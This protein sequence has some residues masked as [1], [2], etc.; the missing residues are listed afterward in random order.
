MT[1]LRRRGLLAGLIAAPLPAAPVLAAPLLAAPLL[2]VPSPAAAAPTAA[3]HS[4]PVSLV[5]GTAEPGGDYVVYGPAW[6]ALATRASG[7]HIS[8]RAT[9]GPSQNIILIEQGAAQLGMTSL[10]V[11]RQAWEGI[12]GWTHAMRLRRARALFPMYPS[13]FHG[14]ARLGTGILRIADLSGRTVGIGPRGGT[15]AEYVPLMLGALGIAPAG[16][17]YG[18]YAEQSRAVVAGGLDACVAA[19]GVPMPAFAALASRVRFKLLGFSRPEMAHVAALLPELRPGVIPAGAYPGLV[20]PVA[21][22]GMF[23]FAIGARELP[24]GL[25][26][27]LTKA[28]MEGR[29]ALRRALP[30]AAASRPENAPEDAVLPFHPGAAAYFRARG[31]AIPGRLVAA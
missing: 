19:T 3:A 15:A 14:I 23:N 17:R 2:A 18:S 26:F 16:F 12:G 10:G 9:E 22:V 30:E 20:R 4:W 7:V 29:A 5:M 27:A 8:Y 6:G 11:A 25:A 28:A 31:V 24:D 21:A 1:V 13:L